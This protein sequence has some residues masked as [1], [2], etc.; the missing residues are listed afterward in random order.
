MSIS[1]LEALERRRT[2]RNYDPE[3]KIP[4]EQLDSIIKAVQLSPTA[5]DLQGEDFIIVT[6]KEKLSELEK[7][8]LSCPPDRPHFRER[9]ERHGVKNV[10]T[11]D[12]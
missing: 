5:G 7:V 4:Q 12:A 3:Y 2:V 1:V 9:R 8:I 11:C 6:N 10:V